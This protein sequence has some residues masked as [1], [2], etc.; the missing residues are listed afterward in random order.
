MLICVVLRIYLRI[1]LRQVYP[2]S[3]SENL[4]LC[5]IWFERRLFCAKNFGRSCV[6]E[7][8]KINVNK[9]YF[10][11]FSKLILLN[12][13]FFFLVFL[14]WVET[15]SILASEVFLQVKLNYFFPLAY[16]PVGL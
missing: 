8:E 4:G 6:K 7:L 16:G 12:F 5:C 10:T 9:I 2:T 3:P 11:F 13:P 14:D 15:I 1:N